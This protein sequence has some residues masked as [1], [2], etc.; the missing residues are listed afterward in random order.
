MT[1]S[2]LASQEWEKVVLAALIQIPNEVYPLICNKVKAED[3]YYDV[4]NTVFCVLFN[5]LEKHEDINVLNLTQKIKNLGISFGAISINDYLNALKKLQISVEAAI[6]AFNGLRNLRV[7]RNICQAANNIELEANKNL[8]E[9]PEGLIS[10]LDQMYGKQ[11]SILDFEEEPINLFDG[12]EEIIN[13]RIKNP[14]EEVG[15]PSPSEN[16][17]RLYGGFLPGNLYAF[18]ARFGAGKTTFLTDW[19]FKIAKNS[20][21]KY[22]VLYLDTEMKEHAMRDRLIAAISGVPLYDI[23]SGKVKKGDLPK[24]NQTLKDIRNYRFFNRYVGNKNIDEICNIVRRFYYKKIGRNSNKG[25]ILVYDYV[26]LT[27]EKVSQN[28][29]EHQAIGDKI[30]KLNAISAE[31]SLICLTSMQMNRS[32]DNFNRQVGQY[33]DDSTAIAQSDRLAWFGSG[34][35]ILRTKGADEIM[36]DGKEFG[37]HKMIKIKSRFQGRDARGHNDFIFREFKNGD[38]R[39]VPNYINFNIKN[40]SVEERGTLEDIVESNSI[41]ADVQKNSKSD[42]KDDIDI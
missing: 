18:V 34:V 14:V 36:E 24:I 16:F 13:E 22:E 38:K 9:S 2:R 20:G 8:S 29:G 27:G 26:K 11:V 7:R 6:E 4:N 17:N 15:V 10:K 37:T 23:M 21:F 33:N 25:L 40:F 41:N 39:L 1:E 12:A 28:W 35:F 31:L 19:S 42:K 32:G 5:M 30:N 3:F